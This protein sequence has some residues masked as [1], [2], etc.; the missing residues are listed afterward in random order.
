MA[1][2]RKVIASREDDLVH[3]GEGDASLINTQ[4]NIAT[5]LEWIDEW[6]KLLTIFTLAFGSIIGFVYLYQGWIE[7]TRVHI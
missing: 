1:G 5:R 7:S 6:G 3:L 2:Y 4:R